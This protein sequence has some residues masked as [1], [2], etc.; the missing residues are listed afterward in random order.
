VAQ[1]SERG[2]LL[3]RR[4]IRQHGGDIADARYAHDGARLLLDYFARFTRR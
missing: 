1:A 4:L 2:L 3:R